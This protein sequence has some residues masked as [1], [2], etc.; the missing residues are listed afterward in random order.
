MQLPFLSL[1]VSLVPFVLR[2]QA[3]S[4]DSTYERI[5][6]RIISAATADSSA[7]ERL[8]Y[9]C[10]T[11]GHR[12]SGSES[13]ERAIDWVLEEMRADG[14]ENVRGQPVRVPVWKRGTE[15]LQL[16]APVERSLV[17]LGLGRSIGTPP[18]GITAPVVV[19]G[20]FEELESHKRDVQGKIVLFNVP[21]TT[22]GETVRYRSSGAI[23]AAKAGAVASLVRS[24]GTVSMET[25]HTGTTRYEEGVRRIPHAAITIEAAELLQ[26]MF[27]RGQQPVVRLHMSAQTHEDGLSRN[28]I[29]ELRG[30]EAP[31]EVVVIGGHIDSWD[32]GQ[33]AMD[34]AGG[35]VV[36]W[37]ALRLLQDLG[38]RPR[39]TIRV[40]LWTN[41]ENGLRGAQTYADSVRVEGAMERHVL[42]VESDGGVFAPVGFGFE[43]SEDAYALVQ[44]IE[45]LL[46][47]LLV[48]S[49]TVY[50]RGI[51]RGGGQR[52]DIGVLTREGVPGMGL[53]TDAERYYWYHHTPADTVDKLDPGEVQRCVAAMAILAF[54]V[55][56]METTLP[57]ERTQIRG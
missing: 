35:S 11:F 40:V 34:D 47:P 49:S 1:L 39:R 56:D 24:V 9:L 23:A 36:A 32:V 7:Y 46:E 25:P 18:E 45:T 33:G 5:A 31:E 54:V 2:L 44:P 55:A 26:R 3:Q 21:F 22:Y 28:V 19:V 20:S 6:E 37:E 17:M 38:L 15:S 51:I 12:F 50:D 8:A 27:D 16:V 10:D 53:H 52:A 41:E 13:L 29:G 14:L 4:P 30:A 48:K 43:G 42:A 57:R